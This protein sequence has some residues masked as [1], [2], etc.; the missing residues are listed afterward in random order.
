MHNW[1]GWP[2][3][4]Q[5]DGEA[6]TADARQG[7]QQQQ[8]GAERIP[9]SL[10]RRRAA[11]AA[12]AAVE[13]AAT[14]DT[15]SEADSE[16][17]G[18]DQEEEADG[19]AGAGHRHR[20]QGGRRGALRQQRQAAQQA[21]QARGARK[22]AYDAQRRE[23]EAAREAEEA[24]REE[25]EREAEEARIAA[26]DAEAAKWMRQFSVEGE[27]AD[28]AATEEEAQDLLA[29][30]IQYIRDRKSVDLEEL[31]V[32]FGMKVQDA[33]NRV[34]SLEASGELTGV[35]DDRGKFIYISREEMEA[36]ASFMKQRGRVAI[37]ELA[38][39]SSQFIDLEEK[40]VHH[41]QLSSLE[42]ESSQQGMDVGVRE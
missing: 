31:A 41:A 22:E 40:A 36:V 4:V 27:G 18:S 2:L 6:Q 16:A 28:A 37:A 26:E 23:K 34:Q 39:K 14:Q 11:A 9:A 13:A 42:E 38:A 19:E 10:R 20:R 5:R 1:T 7:G 35:M 24:D 17:G 3:P 8:A 21:Q 12:A 15:G 32:E 29:N 33:I 30:F 25:A